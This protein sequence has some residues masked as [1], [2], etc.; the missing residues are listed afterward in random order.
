[1]IRRIKFTDKTF[2]LQSLGGSY[3][4][5]HHTLISLCLPHFKQML[6][7][8]FPGNQYFIIQ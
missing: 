2:Q 6:T 8:I 4:Q 3:I 1:M 7:E 5:P